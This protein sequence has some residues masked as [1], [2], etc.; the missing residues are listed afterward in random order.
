MSERSD[1]ESRYARALEHMTEVLLTETDSARVLEGL[2]RI[3]GE[4]LNADRSL[5]YEARLATSEAVGWC[6]WLNPAV[7]VTATKATYPLAAFSGGDEHLR[8][9]RAWMES[10][11]DAQHPAFVG[12]GS[13]SV[14]HGRGPRQMSIQ[15]LLWFPF[16]F[17]E[18]GYYILAF[19][20]VTHRRVWSAREI[21][22]L[23]IATRHAVLALMQIGLQAERAESQR[24]I[25][26]AQKA[27]SIAVLAGGVAHDFNGLL[28]I[29]IGAVGRA[30]SA[31]GDASPLAPG[32][33]D[34]ERAAREAADLAKHLLAFAGGGQLVVET[35]DLVALAE[36]MLDLLRSAAPGLRLT[37]EGDGPC[38]VRGDAGQLRQ[39]LMNFV[40]NA[41]EAIE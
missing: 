28:G 2:V 3:T 33:R 25:L 23:R 7:K 16:D 12:D 22:F 8:R 13:A 10:H 27:E 37:F 36:E 31:L 30:R 39:A 20:Q 26:E 24:T 29:V 41:A 32:L 5:I 14:L 19:N 35:F 11:A 1:L 40:V 15:S 21:D 17:R 34:A 6:E 4:T 18:S 9:T 38:M